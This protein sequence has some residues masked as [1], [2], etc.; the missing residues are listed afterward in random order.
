MA[1][2]S[3]YCECLD[4]P[5]RATALAKALLD[6]TRRRSQAILCVHGLP[7]D[8][9]SLG[10]YHVVPAAPQAADVRFHRRLGGGR[11]APLGE[12]F[13][14]IALA[15]PH[16]GVL[17]DADANAL[18]PAQILNRAVRGLLGALASVGVDAYYP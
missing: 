14:A 13:V 5:A 18:T 17:V 11:A 9:L 10:R 4:E 16:P 1:E 3:V 2:L 6:E 7:G 8:V 12:G 15:L